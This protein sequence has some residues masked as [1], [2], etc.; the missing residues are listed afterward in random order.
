MN[1]TTRWSI[2]YKIVN[3]SLYKGVQRDPERVLDV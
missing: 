2:S 3:F 1:L